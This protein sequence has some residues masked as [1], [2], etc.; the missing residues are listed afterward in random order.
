MELER[1]ETVVRGLMCLF[2]DDGHGGSGQQW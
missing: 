1:I 2:E